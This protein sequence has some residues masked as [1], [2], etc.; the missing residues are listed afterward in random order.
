MNLDNLE[1]LT[2]GEVSLALV[3]RASA[4]ESGPSESAVAGQPAFGGGV[5]VH[6]A[7]VAHSPI[8]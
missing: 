4:S 3:Q 2:C 7:H 8:E 5:G 6:A 1:V